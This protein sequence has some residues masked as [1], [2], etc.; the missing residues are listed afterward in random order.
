[1]IKNSIFLLFV[2]NSFQLFS[3]DVELYKKS[4][5]IDGLK[6]A[7]FFC[8]EM[9]GYGNEAHMRIPK[10][11]AVI[12][13]QQSYL[14][15]KKEVYERF[16]H[17]FHFNRDGYHKMRSDLLKKKNEL[18][19]L[20]AHDKRIWQFS[21]DKRT[22]QCR[23]DN[24]HLICR[25]FDVIQSDDLVFFTQKQDEILSSL[26]FRPKCFHNDKGYFSL[27]LNAQENAKYV[28][29]PN[30]FKQKVET[31]PKFVFPSSSYKISLSDEIMDIEERF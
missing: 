26:I 14:L 20:S 13:A 27:Q 31:Y 23:L 2:L 30:E 25:Q 18:R 7:I 21:L 4:D 3:M 16:D 9:Q 19:P 15:R 6:N 8:K 24:C 5:K 29:L 10:D 22:L 1:M 28:M 12:I 17:F 11:V